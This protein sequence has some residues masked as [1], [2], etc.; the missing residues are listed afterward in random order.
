M[1][2]EVTGIEYTIKGIPRKT[3]DFFCYNQI[4]ITVFRTRNHAVKFFPFFRIRTRDA[5]I[6]EHF[7]KLPIGITF[8]ILS[9]ITLLA[10]K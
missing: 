6:C 9:E 1:L 4:K 7:V 10:F 5:F 8:Y 2:L 3:G